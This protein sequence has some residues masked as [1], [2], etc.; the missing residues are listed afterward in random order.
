M[1]V[2]AAVRTPMRPIFRSIE[3]VLEEKP[4]IR[5]LRL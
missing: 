2:Y 1:A 4:E 5:E 3:S